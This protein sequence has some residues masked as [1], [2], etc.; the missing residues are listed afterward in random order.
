MA[1]KL[2]IRRGLKSALPDLA[3]GELAYATNT[4]EVF[5]GTATSENVQILTGAAG[6]SQE[7][8]NAQKLKTAVNISLIGDVTGTVIFDGSQSVSITA[9][10]VDDS[11]NHIIS[12]V[13]GLQTA[14]DLKAPLAS[15][16]LT[17]VPTAPTAALGDNSTKIATTEFVQQEIQELLGGSSLNDYVTDTELTNALATKA[18]LNHTHTLSSLTDT[19][20]VGA[21]TDGAVLKWSAAAGKWEPGSDEIGEGGEVSG[22]E[23]QIEETPT[24]SSSFLKREVVGG[25][26][27]WVWD[28]NTYLTSSSTITNTNVGTSGVAQYRV[29]MSDG[30]GTSSWQFAKPREDLLLTRT[31]TGSAVPISALTAYDEVILQLKLYVAGSGDDVVNTTVFERQR[32]PVNLFSYSFVSNSLFAGSTTNYAGAKITTSLPANN[33]IASMRVMPVN[34]ALTFLEIAGFSLPTGWELK[35][36]GVKY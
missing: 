19:N 24:T 17:G 11:H 4:K 33:T 18:D 14:L 9:T 10:I 2:Q 27:A 15:P 8:I 12:N 29:L 20:I 7:A 35:I 28:T 3:E 36:Y 31:S 34:S 22:I 16:A 26:K 25:S 13:D 5:I 32:I 1:T 21:I 23:T 30:D 6:V